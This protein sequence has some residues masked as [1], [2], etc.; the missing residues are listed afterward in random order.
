VASS[1]YREDFLDDLKL[2]SIVAERERGLGQK[3]GINTHRRDF[4]IL[5]VIKAWA[6]LVWDEAA[7]AAR[8]AV[9]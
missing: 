8:S 6:G 1:S 7:E 5:V 9:Y 4:L 2:E 3:E